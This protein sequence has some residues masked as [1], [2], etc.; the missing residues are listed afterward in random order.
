MMNLMDIG[1][2]F[3]IPV[4]RAYEGT[5]EN[6]MELARTQQEGEGWVIRFDDGHMLKVKTDAYCAIHKAKSMIT[7]EKA[8]LEC[9]INQGIDDL[10]PIL[11]KEDADKLRRFTTKFWMHVTDFKNQIS[12]K[13][14]NFKCRFATK[15][16]FAIYTATDGTSDMVR[17][18]M[19]ALWDKD[20]DENV[21][22]ELVIERLKKSVNS[23]RKIEENRVL[24]GN[25]RWEY[26]NIEDAE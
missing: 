1:K 4:V 26:H 24:W 10:L 2:K 17:S 22:R 20:V 19:F 16:D 9:I 23:N 7:S 11:Y 6:I 3:N 25:L 15:K 14:W 5:V 8:V 13:F 18:F 21:I 12:S